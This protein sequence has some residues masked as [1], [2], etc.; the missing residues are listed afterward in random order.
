M[1]VGNRVSERQAGGV[2]AAAWAAPLLIAGF[3]TL[4]A[5]FA[6]IG[7]PSLDAS[8]VW[9]VNRAAA[10]GLVWGRD[11]VFTYGPLAWILEPLDV[12]VHLVVANLIRAALHATVVAVWVRQVIRPE[13]RVSAVVVPLLLVAAWVFQPT[14]EA[15]V[16]L[17]VLVVLHAVV[18][19][20]HR[21]AT[22]VA[23]AVAAVTPF[24][25]LS[26]GVAAGVIGVGLAA[27]CALD[28]S[29]R[30]VLPTLLAG[31]LTG[32]VIAAAWLLR[33]PWTIRDWA[34]L[35]LEMTSGYSE[36]ASLIGDPAP[37]AVGLAVT[38]ALAVA[39]VVWRRVPSVGPFLAVAA[40][41][42]VLMFRFAFVRQD[43][44]H[45]EQFVPW[46]LLVLTA[47]AAIAPRG[48]DAIVT[49]A[50]AVVVTLASLVS[51]LA[52]A[53]PLS[54]AAWSASR[55]GGGG[56]LVASFV[57][58][59]SVRARL[60]A[61]GR[62]RLEPLE[63]P[64]SWHAR[65]ASTPV[66][67]LPWQALWCPANGLAWSPTPT[68]QLYAAH[69]AVL[70]RWSAGRYASDTAPEWI[71]DEYVP[72]IQRH[73]ALDA[74]AT[75]LE[76]WRRYEMV[77]AVTD[78]PQT[79]L[80]RR[81]PAPVELDIRQVGSTPLRLDDPDGE[82]VPASEHLLLAAIELS[83]SLTGRMRRLLWRVPP[84]YL[85]LEHASGHR[86]GYRLIPDTARSGVPLNRFPRDFMGWRAL[87]RGAVDDPVVRFGLGG[88]G[89]GA[90]RSPVTVRWLEV[91]RGAPP[92]PEPVNWPSWAEARGQSAEKVT[93]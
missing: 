57:D 73:Q 61:I 29:R 19:A 90:F 62:D 15:W 36:A 77:E 28:R 9:I 91:Q 27:W 21:E 92:D 69:T 24:L 3:I 64:E 66:G 67:T 84:V 93:R 10:D 16:T 17:A 41:V 88:P 79:A 44:S 42:T 74:P 26:L 55:G 8:W 4:P 87:W 58:L 59:G 83:P 23:A 70:D 1:T 25:K 13:R 6:A 71:L 20:R 68:V 81:R 43:A 45:Q 54:M 80:L 37:V 78:E 72:V 76:L 82:P 85:L 52:P 47:L 35:S 50:V 56:R 60:A 46:V 33:S 5:R 32:F 7:P 63:L 22:A 38:A 86:T 11:L 34:R 39:A 75:W 30:Q 12:G 48:R 31:A 40:V 89:L 14:A 65:L 53:P 2:V 51:G 18:D 49:A